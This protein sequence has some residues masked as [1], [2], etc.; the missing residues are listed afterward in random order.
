[1]ES[2][3][4]S[5]SSDDEEETAENV[6]AAEPSVSSKEE[7][8]NNSPVAAAARK[9]DWSAATSKGE[10]LPMDIGKSKKQEVV[11]GCRLFV[12]GVAQVSSLA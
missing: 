10:E 12:R 8:D 11:A 2:S 6:G 3:S 5:N 1:M 4:D 9:V 7:T